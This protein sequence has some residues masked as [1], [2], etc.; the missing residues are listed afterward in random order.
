MAERLETSVTEELESR[1]D[2]F[3]KED[4][5]PLDF[6]KIEDESKAGYFQ[7]IKSI[8]LSIDWEIT[9]EVMTHFIDLLSK[10]EH[11]YRGD[12]N[13]HVFLQM[14]MSIAKYIKVNKA[15]AH[16]SVMKVLN[17]VYSAMERVN[18]DTDTAEEEKEK[19][20]L[21]EVKRFKHLKKQIA[22]SRIKRRTDP[23]DET[24]DAGLSLPKKKK[25]D[26][27]FQRED[28]W[29]GDGARE[30][31]SELEKGPE[32]PHEGFAHALEEIKALIRAEFQALRAELRQ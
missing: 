23:K 14:I 24:P 7:E 1:L 5:G 21:T 13:L 4:E 11:A 18:L 6:T 28:P 9:D 17:S 15:R 32:P 25:K 3:F 2:F 31:P 27:P 19:I 26:M 12:K 20:L 22:A 29:V 16:P 8:L 10:M 30:R